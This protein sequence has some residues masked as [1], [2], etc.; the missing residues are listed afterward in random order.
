MGFSGVLRG[1]VSHQS[2]SSLR[3]RR[4]DLDIKRNI[5]LFLFMSSLDYRYKMETKETLNWA[6]AAVIHEAR[7]RAAL[8][9]V[10][11]ADFSGLSKPYVSGLERGMINASVYAL[12][13]IAEV[14]KLAPSELLARVERELIKGARKP[15]K[16]TGRPK[17]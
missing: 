13:S 15:H 6:M 16:D 1:V 2:E 12:M 5:I 7:Q 14:L 17:K 10:E 11:L 9:Q 8:T 3:A 4:G